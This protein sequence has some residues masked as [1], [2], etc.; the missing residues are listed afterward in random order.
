MG[1]NACVYFV[2]LV[3][4]AQID[5]EEK[6]HDKFKGGGKGKTE[7]VHCELDEKCKLRNS[8]Q[9]DGQGKTEPASMN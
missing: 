6:L 3:V 4:C 2:V 8:G 9:R 1:N 5:R 7:P